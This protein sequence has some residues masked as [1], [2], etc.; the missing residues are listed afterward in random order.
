LVFQVTGTVV[1]LDNDAQAEKHV[2]DTYQMYV[3]NRYCT[4][5]WL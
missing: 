1:L 3:C 2:G 4:F 5:N